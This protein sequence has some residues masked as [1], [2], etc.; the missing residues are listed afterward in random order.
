MYGAA[1]IQQPYSATER[2]NVTSAML[3]AGALPP[4]MHSY[5]A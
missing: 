4:S 3:M 5:A 2:L 1:A